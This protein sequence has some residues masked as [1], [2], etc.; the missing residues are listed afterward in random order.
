MLAYYKEFLEQHHDDPSLRRELDDLGQILDNL[1]VALAERGRPDEAKTLFQRARIIS[2]K[3]RH[4]NSGDSSFQ[5]GVRQAEQH[6]ARL[7]AGWNTPQHTAS[8]DIVKGPGH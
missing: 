2:Q 6:L 5:E 8:T 4:A 3:L 1:G 7:Q